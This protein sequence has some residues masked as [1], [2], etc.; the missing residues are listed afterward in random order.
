MSIV[1]HDYIFHDSRVDESTLLPETLDALEEYNFNYMQNKAGY[2]EE[3][4][5][6]IWSYWLNESGAM[7]GA[8][9]GAD[10]F[11]A[12]ITDTGASKDEALVWHNAWAQSV[13]PRPRPGASEVIVEHIKTETGNNADSNSWNKLI[14]ADFMQFTLKQ[15]GITDEA[16]DSLPVISIPSP[17]LDRRGFSGK[18]SETPLGK[19]AISAIDLCHREDIRTIHVGGVS[20]G[21]AVSAKVVDLGWGQFGIKSAFLGEL[22]NAVRRSP[23]SFAKSYLTDGKDI[24]GNYAEDGPAPRTSIV[25]GSED[26]HMLAQVARNNN[27]IANLRLAN[28]MGRGRFVET[29]GSFASQKVPMTLEYGDMSE[30]SAGVEELLY[31]PLMCRLKCQGLLQML[32]AKNAPHLH[33]EHIVQTTDAVLRSMKFAKGEISS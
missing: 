21:A 12:K 18:S 27:L 1:E 6:S 16:G 29:I 31:Q 15:A 13:A 5:S 32:R 30:V 24:K 14:L 22:P 20:Q 3:L 17:S 8:R 23:I 4:E 28:D 26:S 7:R 25:R 11:Y 9:K 19:L 10:M 2:F 33:S